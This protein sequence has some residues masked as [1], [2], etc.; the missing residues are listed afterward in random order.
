MRKI[1]IILCLGIMSLPASPLCAHPPEKVIL[2]YDQD[3]HALTAEVVHPVFDPSRHYVDRIEVFLNGKKIL[4]KEPARQ[5][6]TSVSE[7][8]PLTDVKSGDSVK[9][10]AFCNK[11]G[12]QSGQIQIALD[13]VP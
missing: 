7:V 13:R 1:L 3:T 4:E 10:I 5:N 8:Y 9:L 12:D 11:G 2:S 6:S